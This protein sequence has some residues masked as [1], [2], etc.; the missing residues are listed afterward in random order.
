M[1]HKKRK[2]KVELK[3]AT[4]LN[5]K[6]LMPKTYT[7]MVKQKKKKINAKNIYNDGK[8]NKILKKKKNTKKEW[9]FVKHKKE[10]RELNQKKKK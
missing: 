5:K 2:K 10:R 8:K 3:I 1:I 6:N 9:K 7:M 4:Y